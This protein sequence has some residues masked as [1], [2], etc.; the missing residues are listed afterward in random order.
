[1]N[2][3]RI[4]SIGLVGILSLIMVGCKS[5]TNFTTYFNTYYNAEKLIEESED[6][7]QYLA[8]KKRIKPR[9]LVHKERKAKTKEDFERKIPD[10]MVE[11]IITKDQ[12]QPVK[13]KL[14]SVLIKGS[15]ILA[16]KRESDYVEKTLYLMAQ[17]YFYR[18]EWLPCQVKCG[19]LIDIYPGGEKSPDAHLLFSKALLIQKK[20]HYGK[21]MLSR[22][23]DIAWQLER[24][25]ILAEAFRLQAALAIYEDDEKAALRPYLQ[26]I[27]Q[28][29]SGKLKARWQLDMASILY[30][31][32]NFKDAEIAFYDVNEKYDPDYLG[33]YEAQLYRADCLS[34][35]GRFEEAEI[36]LEDIYEDGKF[37]EWRDYTFTMKMNLIRYKLLANDSSVKMSDLMTAEEYS[38]TANTGN[39]LALVYLHERGMDFYEQNDYKNAQSYFSKARKA[40]SDI[41]K[42]ATKMYRNLA[43]LSNK[44]RSL[45]RYM[46]PDSVELRRKGENHELAK[47][48]YKIARIHSELENQDSATFY[49]KMAI[50]LAD[51]LNP[52]TAKFIYAYSRQK[53][54][55]EPMAADSLLEQIAEKY[56]NTEAGVESRKFLGFTEA[57]VV[58][59]VAELYK[60]GID[61][62]K[63]NEFAYAVR[64]F[65]DIASNYPKN[66]YAP[67][68]LYAA[69][70]I[71]E[72]EISMRNVDSAIHYYD[73][74]TSKYPKSEY[75]KD[76][77]MSLAYLKKAKF[78]EEVPDSLRFDKLAKSMKPIIKKRAGERV[79]V[80]PGIRVKEDEGF[81]LMNLSPG[82]LFDASK[83][84]LQDQ[85]G[86]ATKPLDELDSLKNKFDSLKT[87]DIDDLKEMADPKKFFK[88]DSASQKKSSKDS[89]SVQDSTKS[90]NK[91]APDSTSGKK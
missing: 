83:K 33:M 64:Q 40:R 47:N 30:E 13:V 27:T 15:K 79:I 89:S 72:K 90:K 50:D 36:I 86:Q 2:K 82:S 17:S 29:G 10:F 14:D 58:D 91:I 76:I 78:G 19:E 60:S 63:F 52:Q 75:A 3:N 9:V 68:A 71:F 31:I 57:F 77:M 45:Q 4:I 44:R 87:M 85:F 65:D 51:T 55:D 66:E 23:V 28:S 21:L 54:E 69:G 6:E 74:L 81:D 8:A 7:F 26:A 32:G 25:D 59:T 62:K 22:T 38:D 35:L 43:E 24:Y 61:L 11:F 1:M 16:L 73:R 37:E 53:R 46:N 67:R 18:S 41:Y 88:L 70:W 56:P 34:R 12:F 5:W 49:Y 84:F 39:R 42:S 48:A 20:F 80:D